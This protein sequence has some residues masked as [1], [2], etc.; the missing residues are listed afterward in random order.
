MNR[1]STEEIRMLVR[2]RG[3][4]KKVTS[5]VKCDHEIAFNLPC[6]PTKCP[7]CGEHILV[8]CDGDEGRC[9]FCGSAE[10]IPAP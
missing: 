7:T 10:R 5:V 4:L 3:V 8:S 1:L 9:K 2:D 6:G